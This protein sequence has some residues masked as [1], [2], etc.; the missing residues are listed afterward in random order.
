M[1]NE[2]DNFDKQ[3]L[4]ELLEQVLEKAQKLEHHSMVT[5][6]EHWIDMLK[7]NPRWWKEL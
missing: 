2:L 5:L 6:V 4:I 7:N 1:T 3:Q